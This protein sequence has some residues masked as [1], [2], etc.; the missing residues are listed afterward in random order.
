[1]RFSLNTTLT[2]FSL[3]LITF[4]FGGLFFLRKELLRV[5]DALKKEPTVITQE[6][7]KGEQQAVAVQ[8]EI[9]RQR[10][11]ALQSKFKDGVVQVFAQVNEFNWL[12]PY[13]T[14]NQAEAL[15]TAFFI[16][17]EGDLI[18][19]AHVVD[20]AILLTIQIQSVGKRRFQVDIIGAS[21]D[22]DL[23]L[24]RLKKE[25][26]Q[27]L[28]KELGLT[29]LPA[30]EMGDSDAIH[31]GDKLMALGYPLGQQG[32][33]STTGVVSG[34]ENLMGQYFIQISAPI[35]KGNSGGPSLDHKGRVIG[36]NTAGI[37][38]AQN[39]GYIIPV[40]EVR[41]FL[42]QL[43]TMPASAAPKLLRKPYMGIFFNNAN[44][45]I[46]AFL[47]NPAPGGL[48]VVDVAKG[49]PFEKVGIKAGD[50]I[51]KIDDYSV[52]IYGEMSVPWSKEDRI[53]IVDYVGR[54][55][56]GH[57][58]RIEYYR[59]GALK[60]ASFTLT[61]VQSP[62]RRMYPGYEKI[63]YEVIAGF[64]IM[65]VTLNHVVLLAQYTHELM[66][67]TDPKKQ[68]EPALMITHVMLNSPASRSRTV[69][70]GG[71]IA[72]VNG[73]RVKTLEEFRAAVPLSI[74]SG[75]LTIKTTDNQFATLPLGEVMADEQRLSA[76]YFY[77][78]SQSYNELKRQLGSDALKK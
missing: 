12:E 15:G 25:D 19:N 64:V 29:A 70:A 76:T 16:N 48:Y 74:K 36:V 60:K 61:P 3:V 47:K 18:T 13:K 10:W 35:N 54:L 9:K 2:S 49:G 52:D 33:K 62:V 65:P 50:M 73:L 4:L 1:M 63:D 6:I 28:K 26:I 72:E 34:R 7:I 77:K 37:P 68:T 51:Y 71:V 56:F 22:R 58:I 45:N 11:S 57:K 27:A 31:R 38:G 30:L 46:T 32:L 8:E 39:V 40:N 67:F 42:D 59:N 41:L 44:D 14:P 53:S 43:S 17:Q 5:E 21:P 55:K 78:L 69:G 75:Y 20:Q 24:V 23:A 66:A